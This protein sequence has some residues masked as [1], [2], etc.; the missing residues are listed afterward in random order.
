MAGGSGD[1]RERSGGG[2][3]ATCLPSRS[4][5]FWSLRRTRVT[6]LDEQ[7]PTRLSCGLPRF[8]PPLMAHAVA[9][10]KHRLPVGALPSHP[11]ALETWSL[12][13]RSPI[14]EPPGQPAWGKMGDSIRK[15]RLRNGLRCSRTSSRLISS[16]VKRST[17]QARVSGPRC[18]RRWK[19]RSN[20]RAGKTRPPA[21]KASHIWPR[22]PQ[23]RAEHRESEPRRC[24]GCPPTPGSNRLHP[25]PHPPLW[26]G[27]A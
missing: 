3:S 4:L 17:R 19:Q 13:A 23:S 10:R 16:G 27:P 6:T 8:L 26:P 21:L 25:S 15:S 24:D 18:L 2:E 5:G 22:C 12:L 9:Q 7:I 14:P 11:G 20:R 1:R